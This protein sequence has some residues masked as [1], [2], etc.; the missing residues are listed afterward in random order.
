MTNRKSRGPLAQDDQAVR[1]YSFI[2][3]T[4]C[5][6]IFHVHVFVRVFRVFYCFGVRK[7]LEKTLMRRWSVERLNRSHERSLIRIALVSFL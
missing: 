1:M 6:F 2:R 3:V 7:A 5:S 4:L